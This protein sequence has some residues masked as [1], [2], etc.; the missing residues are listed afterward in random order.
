M[1]KKVE[2]MAAFFDR[3]AVDYESM[4]LGA[5]DAGMEGKNGISELLPKDA[6]RILDLG[7]GSGLEL[8]QI[9]KEHPNIEVSVVD[10]SKSMLAKLRQRFPDRNIHITVSDYF[11]ADFGID[12]YDAA[13]SS[14]TMHHWLPEEKAKLYP[15]I[16]QAIKSGGLYI[17]NDYILTDGTDAEL[18]DQ[19]DKILAERR[20]LDRENPSISHVHMDVPLT[21]AT[22]TKI[23]LDAGFREVKEVWRSHNNVT[24]VAYR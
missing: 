23:L 9:F 18:E 17:E 19:Q 12:A 5:V 6:K 13:I 24:L 16:C 15:R 22:E 4:H 8:E 10:I 2:E 3:A 1:T 20:K 7:A 21:V 11:Q 14:M